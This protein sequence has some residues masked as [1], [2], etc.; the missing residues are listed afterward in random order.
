MNLS[1]GGPSVFSTNGNAITSNAALLTPTGQ[2]KLKKRKISSAKDRSPDSKADGISGAL[3]NN[4]ASEMNVVAALSSVLD[5]EGSAEK[6][7]TSKNAGAASTTGKGEETKR[8]SLI[9][10]QAAAAKATKMEMYP[11]KLYNKIEDNYHLANKKALFVNMKTY[12]EAVGEDPFLALPVTFHIK[13]G[14]DDPL[15]SQF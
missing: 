11:Y 8:E 1:L 13:D 6:G 15:F 4:K 14:L 10:N 5:K 2:A 3:I 12:Y 7:A 9:A